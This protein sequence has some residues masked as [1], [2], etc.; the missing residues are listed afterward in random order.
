M[1]KRKIDFNVSD[2]FLE[3][4]VIDR[5]TQRSICRVDEP[6]LALSH[7]AVL[8]DTADVV[9]ATVQSQIIKHRIVTEDTIGED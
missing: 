8:A 3:W 6:D 2:T 4:H 7:R 5:A 1:A 9:E